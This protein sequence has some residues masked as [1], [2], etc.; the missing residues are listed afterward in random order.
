MHRYMITITVPWKDR[1]FSSAIL[2]I[3]P[4]GLTVSCPKESGIKVAQLREGPYPEVVFRLLDTNEELRFY[5]RDNR[6]GRGKLLPQ[7][8]EMEEKLTTLNQINKYR[9]LDS[10]P[11]WD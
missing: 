11:F 7:E 10:S 8:T 6:I 1:T 5:L 3:G 4:G 2:Q 9:D